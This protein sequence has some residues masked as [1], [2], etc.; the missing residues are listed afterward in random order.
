[1]RH[2]V[3]AATLCLGLVACVMADGGK[4][5]TGFSVDVDGVTYDISAQDFTLNNGGAPIDGWTEYTVIV[6]GSTVNCGV[7]SG[8]GGVGTGTGRPSLSDAQ[9]MAACARAIR[10]ALSDARGSD[11]EDGGGGY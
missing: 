11:S 9:I 1:M 2:F 6:A 4:V 10:A 8:N 3:L 7:R 5:P